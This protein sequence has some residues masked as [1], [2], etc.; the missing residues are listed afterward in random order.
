MNRSVTTSDGLRLHVEVHGPDD[1]PLTVALAHCWT[2]DREDWH[3]Q[4]RDLLSRY[5]HGVRILTWDHRGHGRSDAA[6]MAACTI[7]RLADDMGVVVD[8]YAAAGPLVLAGH[9][10]G[11]MT[12]MALAEQRPDIVDRA[13]GALFVSTS[14]GELAGVTLGLPEAGARAK[15]QIPRMLAARAR[16][17]SRPHRRRTPTIERWVVQRFLFGHPLRARDAGLVVD[18]I[19]SCPPA[20]MRGFYEDCL[21]H[22]R[23]KALAAYS[24]VPTR[25]LVGQ[26]DLLTPVSHA[27]AIASA[28]G[29]AGLVVAPGAG[30]MLPLERDE[31]VSAE[32]FS[33][34]DRALVRAQNPA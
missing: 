5:G 6:P 18:Q 29:T 32:L 31:L 26:H 34:V 16:L 4:V 25:V 28:V 24:A 17:L 14:C 13:R 22:D 2:A 1:A 20:T 11:G 33:L 12:L 27:R 7:E 9:S 15:A 3:Y 8:T 19:I 10:I 30:H 23:A 21:R